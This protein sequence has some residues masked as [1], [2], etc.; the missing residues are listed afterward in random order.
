MR[1]FLLA[2]FRH[3]IDRT[4]MRRRSINHDLFRIN[5]YSSDSALNTA[6]AIVS[7][8]SYVVSSQLSDEEVAEKKAQAK[9]S[10]NRGLTLLRAKR[11]RE[12]EQLIDLAL[13]GAPWDPHLWHLKLIT[14]KGNS[15][16]AMEAWI[17]LSNLG[18]KKAPAHYE[19]MAAVLCNTN[20]RHVVFELH[21]ELRANDQVGTTK[22]YVY[23]FR[24]CHA[25]PVVQALKVSAQQI[26]QEIQ[27]SPELAHLIE[28]PEVVKAYEAVPA[29]HTRERSTAMLGG[30]GEKS[31]ASIPGYIAQ[32]PSMTLATS[33][34]EHSFSETM[35]RGT[36]EPSTSEQLR[37]KTGGDSQR[38]HTP[39]DSV[40]TVE[41]QS[42]IQP[43]L[44]SLRPSSLAMQQHDFP[45]AGAVKHEPTEDEDSVNRRFDAQ[46]KQ[47]LESHVGP[48]AGTADHAN[49]LQKARALLQEHPTATIDN[50][51][52]IIRN[53]SRAQKSPELQ[54]LLD[55]AVHRGLHP[56]TPTIVSLRAQMRV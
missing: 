38:D 28:A 15:A 39:V 6:D 26:W 22:F 45:T 4:C 43:Q 5:A 29:I 3:G 25:L 33:T 11:P 41:V 47:L 9:Q 30:D 24:A 40:E 21:E 8:R 23:L 27:Q 16:G 52:Y 36:M 2:N 1:R 17:R 53:A 48:R 14:Q 32:P 46:L 54:K 35:S 37:L 44:T 34:R 56:V 55:E 12:A 13:H 49:K 20:A 31:L 51:N 7:Q 50:Y 42:N 19:A 18:V 10:Y